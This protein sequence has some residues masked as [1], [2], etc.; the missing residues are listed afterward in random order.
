MNTYSKIYNDDS[1]QKGFS[2]IG[3]YSNEKKEL[4]KRVGGLISAQAAKR[5]S[6]C[7]LDVGG[8]DGVL[9]ELLAAALAKD[10]FVKPLI[11][12]GNFSVNLIDSSENQVVKAKE[13]SKYLS[14]L[15][16]SCPECGYVSY[17]R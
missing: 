11:E 12:S 17:F 5:Q 15:S 6:L 14:W 16:P 9:W 13:R 7:I 3:L 2:L 1:F 10:T 4:A 8:G